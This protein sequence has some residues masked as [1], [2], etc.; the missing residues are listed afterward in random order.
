MAAQSRSPELRPEIVFLFDLVRQLVEGRV[1]IPRFQR[2][3]V[4]R[5]QQMLDL[6]DSIYNQYPIGSLLTWETD[7][8][9][10]SL[11]HIGPVDL[12]ARSGEGSAAYLLD[13]HQ[14]LST[15]AGA[16]VSSADRSRR[17]TTGD[18]PALWHIFFN[19]R[20]GLF[21]HLE[22]GQDPL[23]Y[24]FP[25]ARLLDTFEF[26][27]ESQRIL[28]TGGEDGKSYLQKIQDVARAFQNYKI[29]V[30][31][32]KQTGL[33]EAV[34]IFARLNSKGQ[35]M[36]A[37]QMVS[38]LLY[39]QGGSRDFDL[40]SEI[41]ASM[42]ILTSYGF[43]GVDRTLVLRAVLAAAG[44]DIYRT[45]WTR[46]A[47]TRRE[48]LLSRLQRV[49]PAVNASLESA[50][51]FLREE[52]N[53]TTD[54]LLPYAMQLVII[55]SLF[56]GTP[57]PSVAQ[58]RLIS[59]W[60]WTTSFSQWFGGA[61]PSRV[62][63]L[64]RDVIDNVS[65]ERN[66]PEFSDFDLDVPASPLPLSF[67]MRSARTRVLLLVLFSLNPKARDGRPVADPAALVARFGPEALGYLAS[68]VG[69]RDV[70]RSPANR[71]LRDDPQDRG[72]ARNW[73]GELRGEARNAIWRSHALPVRDAELLE[74]PDASGFLNARL[75]EMVRVEH[76]F[77][78]RVDVRLPLSDVPAATAAD[79]D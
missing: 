43:G 59:R 44:E 61:N 40:A 9:I 34:E 14:R 69:M 74:I 10:L 77:M 47:Q 57:D 62:N 32:I 79:S 78:A 8:D 41:T 63:A 28:E 20:D 67:D 3:F 1:R 2:P 64:V 12:A 51:K 22:L 60:F 30:I 55:S 6:L 31:Q 39:R 50:A 72:Q 71:I 68:N 48:E 13:G 17:D 42:E 73:L 18:D 76:E 5:R 25:M 38:A 23:P 56:Y 33:T 58:R 66:N 29:P 36:T 11:D 35:S 45:D 54:R 7:T 19:A 49:L 21:E 46:I 15:I 65:L 75:A 53:V 26:L 70:A 37:D 16:L 52:L 4:W 27:A 24:Q